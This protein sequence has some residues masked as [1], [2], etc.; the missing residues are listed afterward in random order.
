[1]DLL[2]PSHLSGLAIRHLMDLENLAQQFLVKGIDTG[3]DTGNPTIMHFA[4]Y[5]F[6]L[7]L[8]TAFLNTPEELS[9]N[10]RNPPTNIDPNDPDLETAPSPKPIS[11]PRSIGSTVKGDDTRAKAF[12]SYEKLPS[13]FSSNKIVP[14]VCEGQQFAIIVTYHPLTIHPLVEE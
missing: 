6:S 10:H 9:R 8:F 2:T 12:S 13:S 5:E 4:D 7:T 3:I 11:I 14:M 1:M